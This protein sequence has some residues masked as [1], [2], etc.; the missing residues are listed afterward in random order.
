M[1]RQFACFDR[2]ALTLAACLPQGETAF[3]TLPAPVGATENWGEP[4]E[5]A[6]YEGGFGAEG[7]ATGFEAAT[8]FEGAAI[9]AIPAVGYVAPDQF[10][11][12][13]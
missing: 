6:G 3:S 5:T 4:P 8:G 2:R 10:G 9:P 11:S 13:F 12:S 7:G 1:A